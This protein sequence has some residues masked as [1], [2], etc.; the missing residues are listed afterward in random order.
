MTEQ[1]ATEL[2]NSLYDSQYHQLVRYALRVCG[3]L[4]SAEDVVQEMF[5]KLYRALR[6]GQNVENPRAWAYCVVR[7]DIGKR[8]GADARFGAA[9]DTLESLEHFPVAQIHAETPDMERDELTGL[10]SV[11]TPREEEVLLLRIGSLKY[12]EI[13]TQL[14]ISSKSVCTMLARA[15][16][17]LKTVARHETGW[18]ELSTHARPAQPRPLQ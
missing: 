12:R 14:G 1:E 18:E 13:A 16:R 6:E 11:L 15:L 2:V 4:D 17:K 9:H 10:M 3:H 7:H 5:M 8:A